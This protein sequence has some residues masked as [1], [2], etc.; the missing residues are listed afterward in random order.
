MVRLAAATRAPSTRPSKE[1]DRSLT[2]GRAR[3]HG[4]SNEAGS[5]SVETLERGCGRCRILHTLTLA[6][7]ARSKQR[8]ARCA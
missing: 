2:T 3:S 4:S 5:S 1:G 7:A 8:W 6:S